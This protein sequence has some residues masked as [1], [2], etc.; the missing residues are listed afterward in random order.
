MEAE[1]KRDIGGNGEKA[2][3]RERAYCVETGSLKSDSAIVTH[4]LL[5]A[6]G[7]MS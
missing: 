4:P 2:G 6:R 5:F 1:L 7:L 3:E